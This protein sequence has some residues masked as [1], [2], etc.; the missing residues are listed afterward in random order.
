MK[1]IEQLVYTRRGYQELSSKSKNKFTSFVDNHLFTLAQQH[2]TYTLD[3]PEV[4]RW[5]QEM[6]TLIIESGNPLSSD[7][8]QRLVKEPSSRGGLEID[9][10]IEE[11]WVQVV[12]ERRAKFRDTGN[13]KPFLFTQDNTGKQYFV[14]RDTLEFEAQI[15]SDLQVG[16]RLEI[17]PESYSQEDGKYPRAIASRLLE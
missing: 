9:E 1:L 17:L 4:V 7:R 5:V 13:Y 6:S 16:D 10:E 14:S 12:I 3:N 11:G 2:N 15:W 8:W